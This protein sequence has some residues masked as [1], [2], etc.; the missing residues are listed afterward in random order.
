MSACGYS[1]V[2]R[3]VF[4][5]SYV[6]H[7]W[8]WD[9]V[10]FSSGSASAFQHCHFTNYFSGINT[11]LRFPV[12]V[13]MHYQ[14]SNHSPIQTWDMN[15]YHPQ[16][17]TCQTQGVFENLILPPGSVSTMSDDGRQRLSRVYFHKHAWPVPSALQQLVSVSR[18][19]M[20][21]KRVFSGLV[22]KFTRRFPSDVVVVVVVVVAASIVVFGCG[23]YTVRDVAVTLLAVA[24]ELALVL[25]LVVIALLHVLHCICCVHS[26]ADVCCVWPQIN[27]ESPHWEILDTFLISFTNLYHISL[28]D[29][30]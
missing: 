22:N 1:P 24:V 17:T 12:I 30:H 20:L 6:T 11:Q 14:T 27:T 15:Q 18:Q 5:S 16:N 9:N 13:S 7:V 3:L 23:W 4:Q 26:L 29:N 21:L 28:S 25:D 2:S 19:E 8:G 10:I